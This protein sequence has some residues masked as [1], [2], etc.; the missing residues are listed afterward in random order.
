MTHSTSSI[1]KR[2]CP[3]APLATL[4]LLLGA[5]SEQP[6]SSSAISSS[7]APNLVIAGAQPKTRLEE[8]GVGLAT[9]L[10]TP[11]SRAWLLNSLASSPYVEDRIP[12]RRLFAA[13]SS[14]NVR[15]IIQR[16][17]RPLTA[18]QLS[19]L[20]E[21][22]LYIPVKAHRAS[23]SVSSAFQVAVRGHADSFYVIRPDGSAFRDNEWF[24][25][26][27]TVTVALGRSEIQYDDAATAIKGGA[28]TGTG[29]KARMAE[30]GMLPT[31]E[32]I[33]AYYNRH[34]A[35][36]TIPRAECDPEIQNCGGGGGNP[37]PPPSG[38][39]T[40]QKTYL[41]L[42]RLNSHFEGLA[43]GDNE[44]EVFGYVNGAYA[45]CAQLTN[46]WWGPSE[47]V[48]IT[49][50]NPAHVMATAIPTGTYKFTL[51]AYEDDNDRCARRDED[52]YLGPWATGI[53][54]NQYGQNIQ[55][56]FPTDAPY[57]HARIAAIARP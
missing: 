11:A 24:D 18:D 17:G 21:L 23:A 44:I 31:E 22:E 56:S 47:T 8:I 26:G 16:S 50:A 48:V 32:S 2:R 15:L 10:R 57:G 42:F 12:L 3:Q 38:G 33:L 14:D 41:A 20:P 13:D 27:E 30:L 36:T 6:A 52:D 49:T 1:R 46:V 37:L 34:A 51:Q 5:C 9:A 43:M 53:T 29:L 55:N 40:A 45:S 25:P 39:S 54:V 4:L 19:Q 7:D 35:P 28:L